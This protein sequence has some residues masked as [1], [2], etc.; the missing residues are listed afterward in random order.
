[1]TGLT[2]A[3]YHT[4]VAFNTAERYLRLYCRYPQVLRRLNTEWDGAWKALRRISFAALARRLLRD[5]AVEHWRALVGQVSIEGEPR[6]LATGYIVAAFHSPWD[7]LLMRLPVFE[8]FLVLANM[9]MASILGG[10]YVARDR[11]GLRKL[12]RHIKSG[13]RVA[14][15]MDAFIEEGH[16]AASFLGAPVRVRAGAIRLAAYTQVPIVPLS[17]TY[18][19]GCLRVRF[20]P[21]VPVNAGVEQEAAAT[22][23]VLECFERAVREDPAA[24]RYLVGFLKKCV[25]RYGHSPELGGPKSSLSAET[26][27]EFSGPSVTFR[28][29]AS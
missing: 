23:A 15:M 27:P 19:R 5:P 13:G 12:V 20:G 21:L 29:N 4:Y 17:T 7:S 9:E 11:G 2:L 24:W 18:A 3:L 22:C 28:G 10:L 26:R 8:G 16:P 25:T 14:V 1:M 6:W